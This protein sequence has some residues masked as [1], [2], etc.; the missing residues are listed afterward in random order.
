MNFY[1]L[2]LR[3]D[4]AYDSTSIFLAS[5]LCEDQSCR[6]EGRLAGAGHE[7]AAPRAYYKRGWEPRARA[8][9]L[10]PA[11]ELNRELG[12][13]RG[14]R[15]ACCL[16]GELSLGAAPPL[17][18]RA[19]SGSSWGLVLVPALCGEQ[20]QAVGEPQPGMSRKHI[21]PVFSEFSLYEECG[22][23]ER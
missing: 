3:A 4:E 15:K 9:A 6:Q 20:T 19:L 5:E 21:V 2:H 8:G 23:E 12:G 10:S 11:E 22:L 18:W 14:N 17:A 1:T 13:Q 16:P 7:A